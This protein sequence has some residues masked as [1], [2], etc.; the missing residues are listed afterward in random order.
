MGQARQ[1]GNGADRCQD[2]SVPLAQAVAGFAQGL[3][4][5]AQ[6]LRGEPIR[7]RQEHSL[8]EGPVY[9]PPT[10]RWMEGCVNSQTLNRE[11]DTSSR[12]SRV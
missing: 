9:F 3:P 1:A 12:T 4:S 2:W 7:T 10:Y 8:M 11:T 6:V 5:T